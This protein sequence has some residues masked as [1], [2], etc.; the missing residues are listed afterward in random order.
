MIIAA[1]DQ[2]DL[3]QIRVQVL[4]RT[5]PAEPSP[6]MITLHG[7]FTRNSRLSGRYGATPALQTPVYL[8]HRNWNF[9]IGSGHC[10]LPAQAGIEE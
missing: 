6:T 2:S 5:K 9:S 7:L 8:P 3:D 1:I 4:G 10:G